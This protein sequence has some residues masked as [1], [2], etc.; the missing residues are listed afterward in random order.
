VDEL[1][2]FVFSAF[3]ACVSLIAARNSDPVLAAVRKVRI[4]MDVEFELSVKLSAEE[5]AIFR[6]AITQSATVT[7]W[8]AAATMLV[9]QLRLRRARY[10]VRRLGQSQLSSSSYDAAL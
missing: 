7:D 1:N 3:V 4:R 8:T 10:E 2:L 6:E 5:I 9:R